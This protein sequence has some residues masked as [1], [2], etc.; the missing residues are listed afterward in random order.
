IKVCH[1]KFLRWY[2]YNNKSSSGTCFDRPEKSMHTATSPFGLALH[3]GLASHY[4]L[5]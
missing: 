5:A 3:S 1:D 2:W 4:R